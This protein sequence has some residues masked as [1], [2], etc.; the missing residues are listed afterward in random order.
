V[1]S[2]D[3]SLD[4]AR[5]LAGSDIDFFFADFIPAKSE[6]EKTSWAFIVCD[7]F[8]TPPD[9]FIRLSKLAPLIGIDEGG[10]CRNDFPFLL[11]LLPLLPQ[12]GTPNLLRPG[13]LDLPKNR[14]FFWGG[15]AF[16]FPP[17]NEG[18]IKILISFG[19]EDSAHLTSAAVQICSRLHNARI[20]VIQGALNHAEYQTP[21]G[22]HAHINV[23]K[24]IPDIKETL[25]GYDLV[26]THFGLTAFES[27]YAGVPVILMAPTAYHKKLSLSAGFFFVKSTNIILDEQT[28]D[29][30]ASRS[31]AVAHTYHFDEEPQTT[32]VEYIASLNPSRSLNCP[33]CGCKSSTVARFPDKTY[34]RC[35]RCGTIYMLRIQ[36]AQIEYSSEYFFESYKKQY[37]K[38]YLEDFSNLTAM[39]RLRL[40]YICATLPSPPPKKNGADYTVLDIGCAYGAFLVAAREE[41]FIP[42]GIDPAAEAAEYVSNTF[43]IPAYT[44]YFPQ[45]F[46]GG[47]IEAIEAKEFDVITMWY[48]IEHFENPL[49]AIQ[50]VHALLKTGGVFA[51]STPSAAGVSGVFS[52]RSFLQ[53]SPADHWTLWNPRQAK[54]IMRR[55]GFSVSKIVISGHHPERFPFMGALA[56]KKNSVLY[57]LLMRI[58]IICKLG[59]T[60]ELYAVKTKDGDIA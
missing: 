45:F 42:S 48:V 44:G 56:S 39:A 49:P 1:L 22:G 51:F 24:S 38:T 30:I 29:A 40:K 50:K 9:E 27:L 4:E 31:K 28:L 8:E 26:I 53:N 37:G 55:A 41:G 3:R 19:A 33:F 54:K 23:V 21:R 16:T 46:F 32:F 15:E 10:Q 47:G 14:I 60:F 59:D 18:G 17:K 43:N 25:A 36:D 58:S 12:R 2:G 6:L 11:D 5:E 20:T 7:R 35:T 52:K 13:L 34:R 57:K